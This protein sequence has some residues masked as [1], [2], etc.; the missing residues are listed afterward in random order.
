MNLYT[1]CIS[2]FM[3]IPELNFNYL[4]CK[5]SSLRND[6]SGGLYNTSRYVYMYIHWEKSDYNC[7]LNVIKSTYFYI[8]FYYNV[9]NNL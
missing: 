9:N 1:F 4:K 5:N 8:H 7:K 6:V 2:I 3:V